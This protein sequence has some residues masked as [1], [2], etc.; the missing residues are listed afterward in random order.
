[1]R[2]AVPCRR[3]VLVSIEG[4]SGTGKTYLTNRLLAESLSLTGDTV[5]VDE[6]S[7]R[8]AHGE[9]GHDLLH[10]L[11]D[12][13]S[14]DPLLRGGQPAAETLLLLAIKTYDYEAHCSPALRR[15]QL[16]LEGRSLYCVAVYQS[17]IMYLCDEKHAR[18]EMQAILGIAARWRPL[19]DL[20]F[21]ITDDAAKAAERAE[22]RDGR[23]FSPGYRQIHHRAAALYDQ[24][25]A[26][27]PGNIMVIDRRYLNARDAIT[28]MRTRIQEQ[29]LA[30]RPN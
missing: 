30:H 10:A 2:P 29:Q 11:A 7:R 12:A 15:G 17:L 18:Q 13:S 25:A 14:G 8:P 28:L 21:L 20:T 27:A 23:T 24:A 1:M 4:I 9:L 26:D 22:Q 5:V 19:P 6:F 3:G 16:V